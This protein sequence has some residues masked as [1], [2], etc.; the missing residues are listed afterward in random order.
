MRNISSKSYREN[1]NTHFFVQLTS[2]KNH[3]VYEIIWRNLVE[4]EWS[5]VQCKHFACEITVERIH[6]HTHTHTEYCVSTGMVVTQT[7]LNGTLVCTLL[8]FS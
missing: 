5:Q 8:F 1:Q 2:S 4:P 7:C 3:A 6:T